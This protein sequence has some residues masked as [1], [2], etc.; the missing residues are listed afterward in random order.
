MSAAIPLQQIGIGGLCISAFQVSAHCSQT[1]LSWFS[2]GIDAMSVQ[3]Y[4]SNSKMLHL[5]QFKCQDQQI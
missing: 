5:C 2:D 3:S 1:D 4:F